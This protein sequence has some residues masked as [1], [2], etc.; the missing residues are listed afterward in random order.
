MDDVFVIELSLASVV[1]EI[2]QALD[3]NKCNVDMVKNLVRLIHMS[4]NVLGFHA[5]NDTEIRKKLEHFDAIFNTLCARIGPDL[6]SQ[7]ECEEQTNRPSLPVTTIPID[8]YQFNME[9]CS[10]PLHVEEL[11]EKYHKSFKGR[12]HAILKLLHIS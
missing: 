6:I 4:K 10:K 11:R 8:V 1:S 2:R 9:G 3:E 7:A 12:T 5:A